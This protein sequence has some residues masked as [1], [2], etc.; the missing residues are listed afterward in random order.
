MTAFHNE[1]KAGW[2]ANATSET[3]SD[4]KNFLSNLDSMNS[5]ESPGLYGSFSLDVMIR[6][7]IKTMNVIT[8]QKYIKPSIFNSC[9]FLLIING[10]IHVASIRTLNHLLPKNEY[11]CCFTY[12]ISWIKELDK[13][14]KIIM[15][16]IGNNP[17]SKN[18]MQ[19][20]M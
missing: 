10:N 7:S 20:A 4:D 14:A 12:G 11:S 9:I 17:K 6:Y 3:E 15:Y 18:V 13:P 16:A 19:L 1:K 5:F 8:T 2:N